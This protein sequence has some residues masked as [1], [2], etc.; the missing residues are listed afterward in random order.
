MLTTFLL[1]L[2]TIVNDFYFISYGVNSMAPRK[3]RATIVVTPKITRRRISKQRQIEE[4]KKESTRLEQF[5]G[6][7]GSTRLEKSIEEKRSTRL[8]KSM[9]EK[10]EETGGADTSSTNADASNNK[11]KSNEN[12]EGENRGFEDKQRTKHQHDTPILEE[13]TSHV[14]ESS[15]TSP[16]PDTS[17]VKP[18]RY[19]DY[20]FETLIERYQG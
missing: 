10:D 14:V 13:E 18:I 1:L 15:S 19:L 17:L 11:F 12:A 20:S 16:S 3:R 8:G 7:D 6:E 2:V 5:I 4:E 9:E